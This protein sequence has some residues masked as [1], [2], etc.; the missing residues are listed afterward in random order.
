VIGK[1]KMARHFTLTITDD[2]LAAERRQD[3]I[4]AEAALDGIY[5]IRTPVPG[6]ELDAPGIVTAY[7]NLKYVERSKPQCCHSRGWSALSCV[8][9]RSV[10][11]K[12][13]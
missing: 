11:I 8:P 13:A 12:A 7:K 4:D 9:S 2:R 6:A 10:L 1:H 5:V 3:S